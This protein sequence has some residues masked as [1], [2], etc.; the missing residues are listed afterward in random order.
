MGSE[1]ERLL[2]NLYEKLPKKQEYSER[3]EI[4]KLESFVEGNRTIVK[5]F[6][7]VCDRLRRDPVL[8]MKYFVKKLAV[9]SEIQ[10]ER[11]LLQR[12]LTNDVLNMRLKEFVDNYVICKECKRPDTHVE[13][14]GRGTKILVCES[15]G[16]KSTIKE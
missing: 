2:D 5:N 3:F 7:A 15:C 10:G 14:A 1:Y 11:L 16:A 13:D 6:K 12:K 9:P 4:P 8:V